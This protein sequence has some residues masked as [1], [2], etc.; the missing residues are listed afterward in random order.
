MEIASITP[1]LAGQVWLKSID[2]PS[3]NQVVTVSDYADIERPARV[4]IFPIAGR[5]APVATTD[6]RGVRR[7]A[8]DLVTNDDDADRK[9]E[10]AIMG[11]GVIFLHVPTTTGNALLPGSMHAVAERM[12]KH[13]IGGVSDHNRFTLELTEVTP[14]GPDV[15]GTTLT[16]R[17][18]A[19]LY[20]SW[21]A[22]LGAHPDWLDLLATVGDPDDLV[23]L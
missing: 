7:W 9:L 22:L 12:L 13:R 16:W 15:I 18:V 10:L 20:G 17:T 21:D 11:T 4:G 2:H 1:S 14:P 5:S 23:V 19:R 3:L 8:I 6:I